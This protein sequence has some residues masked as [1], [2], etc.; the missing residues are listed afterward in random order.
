ML[1]HDSTPHASASGAANQAG[2]FIST[3]MK[4]ALSFA[5]QV[6]RMR[7]HGLVVDDEDE[8]IH[9][10]SEAN[11]YRIRGYWLTF[12]H[13]G[14]LDA[15][16]T[17]D[18]IREVYRLDEE[19]RLWLWA[20]IGQVEIKARTAFAYHLSM[21]CGPLAHEDQKY[22]DDQKAHAKTIRSYE[23]EKS[24]AQR[25]GVPCVVHN[26]SK[27]G[28]LPLWAAVEIMTMGN[29]SRLYGNLSDAASYAGGRTVSKAVADEFKIKPYHLKSWLQHLTYV[30]NLCGYHNRIYNRTVTTRATLL[31]ADSKY[32]GSKAFP[33]FLVLMRIYEKLWPKQ[34]ERMAQRLGDIVSRHPSVSLRPLGFPE[35]WKTI[36]SV[37]STQERP[38]P[39]LL[40]RMKRFLCG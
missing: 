1:V 34:W 33:T 24:R 11:Y 32:Q 7:S 28:D 22:F 23:R 31:K 40:A 38:R 21:A 29:V 13:N 18:D 30:R 10:L 39:G 4:P 8:A 16:T 20:A 9:F 12:E 14:K 3:P 2:S 27:Y 15:G 36:L 35:D 25:D 6:R 5:E 26:M 37:P 17:L 19:L